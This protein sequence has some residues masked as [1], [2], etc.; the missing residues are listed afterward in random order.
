MKNPIKNFTIKLL[1]TALTGFY[2]FAANDEFSVG[3]DTASDDIQYRSSQKRGCRDT[4]EHSV[5]EERAAL[6]QRTLE[7]TTEEKKAIK[8]LKRCFVT[9]SALEQ[10]IELLK[11]RAVSSPK[12][13][14]A[15]MKYYSDIRHFNK[16]EYVMYLEKAV[17]L[18]PDGELYYKL[19]EHN[20]NRVNKVR[21][22][23]DKISTLKQVISYY[24]QSA[25]HGY[26]GAYKIIARIFHEPDKYVNGEKK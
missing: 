7:S 25:S 12:A 2:S 17:T 4:A 6:R 13:C 9:N 14:R 5:E 3:D 22:R 8:M 20:L 24:K 10:A 26:L 1:A 11:E 21:K 23:N 19:A 18:E 15:L 16:I